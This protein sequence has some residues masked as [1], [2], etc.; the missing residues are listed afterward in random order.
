MIND[1]KTGHEIALVIEQY[2]LAFKYERERANNALDQIRK[3]GT[4]EG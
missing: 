1:K 3:M 2:V 4:I